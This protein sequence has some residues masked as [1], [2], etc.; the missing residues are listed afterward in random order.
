MRPHDSAVT[1]PGQQGCD[2]TQPLDPRH[3]AA[4]E[5]FLA[6]QSVPEI[7]SAAGVSRSTAW[8]WLQRVDCQAAIAEAQRCAAEGAIATLRVAAQK[9]ARCVVALLDDPEASLRLRAA[10]AL[11]TRCGVVGLVGPP[12]EPESLLPPAAWCEPSDAEPDR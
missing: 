4:V 7:A 6:G 10:E 1:D 3:E 8:R 12:P 11:L 5:S 2:S 9:A